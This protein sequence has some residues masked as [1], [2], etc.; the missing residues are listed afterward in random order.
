MPWQHPLSRRWM[1][2]YANPAQTLQYDCTHVMGVSVVV[3]VVVVE[4][5]LLEVIILLQNEHVSIDRP[6]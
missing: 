4:T 1:R 2:L 5:R 6:G 3:V